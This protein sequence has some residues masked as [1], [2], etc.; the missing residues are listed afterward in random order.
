[1]KKPNIILSKKRMM[2]PAKLNQNMKRE[3]SLIPLQTQLRRNDMISEGIGGEV[4]GHLMIVEQGEASKTNLEEVIEGSKEI[5]MTLTTGE[6]S[7]EGSADN[8]TTTTS[9]RKSLTPLMTQMKSEEREKVKSTDKR[10]V[11]STA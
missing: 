1:M 4:E 10:T 3:I 5:T 8:M 2:K 11:S 7:K 9:T 6:A